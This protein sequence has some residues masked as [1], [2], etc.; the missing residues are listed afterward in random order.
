MRHRN[1]EVSFSPAD[2]DAFLATT[3]APSPEETLAELEEMAETEYELAGCPADHD[4]FVDHFIN[5]H[6]G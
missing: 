4:G 1:R 3:L 2:I 6:I 5:G